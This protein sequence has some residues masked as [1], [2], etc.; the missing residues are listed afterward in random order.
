MEEWRMLQKVIRD[1]YERKHEQ[2]PDASFESCFPAKGVKV[3]AGDRRFIPV[4]L[5]ASVLLAIAAL[6]LFQ[7]YGPVSGGSTTALQQAL[8]GSEV[9]GLSPG[10]AETLARELERFEATPDAGMKGKLLARLLDDRDLGLSNIQAVAITGLVGL[11]NTGEV[12]GSGEADWMN[13]VQLGTFMA[14]CSTHCHGT[15]GIESLDYSYLSG[16]LV[17]CIGSPSAVSAVSGLMKCG[18]ENRSGRV[19]DGVN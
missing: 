4:G 2:L 3:A 18:P 19:R 16:Y 5:A 10:Q 14:D 17:D 13:E 1:F 6:L 15:A 8:R 7:D 11:W 9:L 12:A